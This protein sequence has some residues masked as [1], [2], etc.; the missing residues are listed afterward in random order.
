MLLAS[1]NQTQFLLAAL[2]FSAA[3]PF[4][5]GIGALISSYCNSACILLLGPIPSAVSPW[6]R[7]C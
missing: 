1:V 3:T 6:L 2:V 7:I 5:V 4:G